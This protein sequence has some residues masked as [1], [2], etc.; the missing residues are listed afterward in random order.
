MKNEIFKLSDIKAGYLLHIKDLE[1]ERDFFATVMPVVG[2]EMPS[3]A[4]LLFHMTDVD[5]GDLAVCSKEGDYDMLK[6]FDDDL[7]LDY[8]EWRIDAVYGLTTPK[9]LLDCS[10]E[11][12]E[13]LWEREDVAED[14]EGEK[15]VVK[16]TVAEI[17]DALGYEVEVVK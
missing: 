13:L 7:L 11:D 15:P 8:A 4:K 10:T 2:H 9:F 3:F 12:R 6:D 5:D 17:C 16:M 14:E 1:D